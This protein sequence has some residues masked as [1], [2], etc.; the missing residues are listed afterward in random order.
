M[1]LV[2]GVDSSTQSCKVVV[3]DARHRRRRARGA[4]VAPR[5][6]RGRP[7]R[8]VGRA[9]GG[10]RR[11]RRPRRRRRDRRSAGSSTAWSCSTPTAAVIRDALLWNDTRSAR[12]RADLIAEFGAEELAAAHRARARGLL[13]RHEAALAARRRARERGAGRRGRAAA[14]LA[15]LAP[16]RLR[17]GG[18]VRLSGPCSTSSPPTD[19]MPR[20]TG[21]WTPA[22]GGYDRELLDRR[23][24][25]RRG[26][27][28]ACSA[29]RSAGVDGCRAG[30]PS[31]AAGAGDNAGAALGLGA[32][33]GRRRRLDRH[34]RHRL[35]GQRRRR[36]TTPPAPSPASPTATGE[37]LPLVAT[38][39]AARVLDVDRGAARRRPRRARPRSRSRAEPG[40]G[41]LVLVPYFE[42]ERTPNLPDATA[43][44]A[45]HDPRPR[46][47]ART[48]RARRSRACSAASP[49]ASTRVARPGRRRPSALLLIGGAAQNPAV[50]G[51]R[52][53]GVRRAGRGARARASTSRSAPPCRRPGRSVP[54]RG[55]EPDPSG[56]APP[57]PSRPSTRDR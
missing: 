22:T 28:R 15:D 44:A 39:N 9:A 45:R 19:R 46:R 35:R 42:G 32:G 18:R 37:F 55:P 56:T 57:L 29:R 25:A 51:D 6:H 30:R 31:S 38:L 52:G 2:A 48:S 13:H 43:I 54:L 16:A 3:R 50:R 14:R 47:P 40:A 5:R 26:P 33:A 53:A 20:G 8:V 1:T 24:R 41:G 27:A 36:R 7:R 11:R 12:R 4:R 10:D 21:Y 17:A 34:E 23:A 49:T